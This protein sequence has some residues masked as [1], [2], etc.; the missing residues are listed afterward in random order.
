MDKTFLMIF[1]SLGFI[2]ISILFGWLA[3]RPSK[4]RDEFGMESTRYIKERD[5]PIIM[6][7]VWGCS[8]IS[9]WLGFLV[10]L[11]LHDAL[12]R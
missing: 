6:S 9:L 5:K 11:W 8:F 7:L 4:V 10:A 1:I 12:T 3:T 2:I